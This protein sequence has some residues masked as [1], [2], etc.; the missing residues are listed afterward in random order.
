MRRGRLERSRALGPS[1]ELG[2]DDL[3]G[4]QAPNQFFWPKTQRMPRSHRH[5]RK[6]FWATSS[7]H[8]LKKNR[9]R[10]ETVSSFRAMSSQSCKHG[11]HND[12]NCICAATSSSD[13]WY[14]CSPIALL[15]LI[16]CNS[17]AVQQLMRRTTTINCIILAIGGLFVAVDIQLVEAAMRHSTPSS[18]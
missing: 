8:E 14:A 13:S 12:Q 10:S 15:R 2:P 9:R 11:L 6:C 7:V 16:C 1:F 3:K 18:V 5:N 17:G 4:F